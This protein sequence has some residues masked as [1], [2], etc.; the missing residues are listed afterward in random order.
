[1]RIRYWIKSHL[2]ATF[3]YRRVVIKIHIRMLRLNLPVPV[4]TVATVC[5]LCTVQYWLVQYCAPCMYAGF[6]TCST[7]QYCTVPNG[8]ESLWSCMSLPVANRFERISIKIINYY[9]I[10]FHGKTLCKL[11]N[12]PIAL[13]CM[14]LYSTVWQQDV[15]GE[16]P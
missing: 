7:V 16:S 10:S 8:E 12:T 4:Y 14:I 9:T 15:I 11:H 3:G 1:M 13:Y 6:L 2:F 5:T